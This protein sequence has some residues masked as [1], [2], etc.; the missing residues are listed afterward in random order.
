[1]KPIK[2]YEPA[3]SDGYKPSGDGIFFLEESAAL[4][5]SQKRHGGHSTSPIHHHALENTD[6]RFFLLKS[7]STVALA[8]SEH[9]RRDLAA[10]ARA[11]LTKE[12]LAALNGE[13]IKQL[14]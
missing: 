7:A 12:E 5:S 6:G 10:T 2:L 14:Q 11:K 3:S 13:L 4:M 8:N 9:A 1:M